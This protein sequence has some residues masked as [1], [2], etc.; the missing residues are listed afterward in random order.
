MGVPVTGEYEFLFIG[1]FFVLE[2]KWER[3]AF[4]LGIYCSY[5]TSLKVSGVV[6]ACNEILSGYERMRIHS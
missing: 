1:C 6:P 5:L 2:K 4:I 3:D